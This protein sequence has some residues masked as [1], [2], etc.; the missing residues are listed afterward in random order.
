MTANQPTTGLQVL[1][2]KSHDLEERVQR[3]QQTIEQLRLD[4][5]R[6]LNEEEYQVMPAPRSA[7]L[8]STPRARRA[9]GGR[10]TASRRAR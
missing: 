4:L 3:L 7:Q 5:G 10:D 1:I 8:A 6:V 9:G 2:E